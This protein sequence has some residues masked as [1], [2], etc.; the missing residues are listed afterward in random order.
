VQKGQ[1]LLSLDYTDVLKESYTALMD[2]LHTVSQKR[3]D[4]YWAE[5]SV[6]DSALDDLAGK[7]EDWLQAEAAQVQAKAL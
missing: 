2:A 6:S 5:A 3:Q 4:Y 7:R 1:P